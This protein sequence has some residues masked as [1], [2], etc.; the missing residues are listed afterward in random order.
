MDYITSALLN[1][2]QL[3]TRTETEQYREMKRERE[4]VNHR[5]LL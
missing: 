5:R 2:Q 4:R 3:K 1:T